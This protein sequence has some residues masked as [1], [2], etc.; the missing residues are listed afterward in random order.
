MQISLR[1]RRLVAAFSLML[2]CLAAQSPAFAARTQEADFIR[3]N[4]ETTADKPFGVRGNLL[5][6]SDG[7]IYYAS[8]L[9]GS[10]RGSIGKLTP[11]GT[12]ST[13]YAFPAEGDPPVRPQGNLIQ[14]NDGHLYGTSFIGGVEGAG[15]IF[16]VTLTGQFTLLRSMGA[17]ATDASLPYT[18]LV[19]GPDNNLYGTTL[20]GGNNDKGAIFRIALDGSNFEIVHHFSGANGEN[21]E[22]QLLVGA[23]GEMYG[24]TLQGGA[25]NRGAIYK[26]STGGFFT[27][28]Y[29]FPSLSA[30]GDIGTAVNATG[31]NP[32]AGL[33]LAADGN[34]YGTAYQGGPGG[35][36]TVFRMTPAGVV[37]VFHA[38]AGP[39]EDGGFPL[40]SLT[41]DAQGNFYGTTQHGS[42]QD[43][44]SAYR[45]SSSGEFTLLHGFVDSTVDGSNPHASLLLANGAI[46]GASCNCEPS[47]NSNLGTLFKL[48]L[49]SNGALPVEISV[50][51]AKA[52]CVSTTAG[53]CG[54]TATITWSSPTAASAKCNA[55]GSWANGERAAS[56]TETVTLT[57][58]SIYIY[59]LSCTDGAGVVRVTHAAITAESPGRT[60]VDGGGGT[61]ALSMTL[62]LLLAM[63]LLGRKLREKFTACP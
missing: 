37:S 41:Q 4:T 50:S 60:P 44:G 57:N 42:Y 29:S 5:L 28:L 62:L 27:L 55:T 47:S 40:S 17:T 33:M 61:G 10:G 31:A 58:P 43:V 36:G 30:F 53:A 23:D 6:A 52:T 39:T 59:A 16:R 35:N 34:Y 1:P 26:I 14:A 3:L 49:G 51:P 22:G 8:T 45:L 19:Q 32:R 11:D 7:N 63:L 25:S 20:R 13:L 21:P 15:T 46:Y 48:D 38:F 24:T 12:I 2:T 56:G 54:V 18:G 9:G